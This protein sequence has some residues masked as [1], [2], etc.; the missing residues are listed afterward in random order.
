MI[1]DFC[2][3]L[4]GVW[5]GL[6]YALFALLVVLGLVSGLLAFVDAVSCQ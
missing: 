6:G 4:A 3:F 1:D 2:E 5:L